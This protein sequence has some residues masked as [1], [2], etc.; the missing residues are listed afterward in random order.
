MLDGD[1]VETFD[2]VTL[3]EVVP[4]VDDD[5]DDVEALDDVALDE[6][7]S[8]VDDDVD[9]VETFDDVDA[10]PEDIALVVLLYEE[11]CGAEGVAVGVGVSA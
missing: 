11:T 6:V 1:D 10:V 4:V 8:V 5:V 7:V 2:D 9:D 3:D